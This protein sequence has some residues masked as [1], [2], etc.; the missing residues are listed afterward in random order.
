[1]L[2]RVLLTA[3]PVHAVMLMMIK[4]VDAHEES[5]PRALQRFLGS[6]AETWVMGKP[7]LNFAVSQP[8][9]IETLIN[10]L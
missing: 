5:G 6:W 4:T 2:H 8:L 10:V 1:M 9:V 7:F 3:V